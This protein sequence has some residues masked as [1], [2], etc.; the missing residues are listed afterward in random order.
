MIIRYPTGL[1]SNILPQNPQDS[2][3][4]TFVISN[5]PPP[6]TNLIFPK[7]PLGIVDKKKQ[8]REIDAVN[9]RN[10]V[11][12]LIF[13]V[14]K[15]RRDIEGNNGKMF[16][17]GQVLEFNN[18][19]TKTLSPMLV[20]SK[21]ITQHN[22]NK[23]NYD[24]LGVDSNEQQLIGDSSLLTYRKLSDELNIIKRKRENAEQLILLNQKIIND[25]NR[26]L[27]A[28][29]I[30]QQ[31]NVNDDDINQLIIKVERRKSL[32][33]QER[34]SAVNIANQ[35]SDMASKILDELRSISTVMV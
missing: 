14:S 29:K 4:I 2:G 26:T 33:E 31:Q 23:I 5:N 3:N 9:R 25:S 27:N 20:G 7:I 10:T 34:D 15:S 19:S 11:G 24:E 16:E 35:S 13:E 18:N 17:I 22:L 21:T 8:R 12:D 6:R 28:L 1:Y 30:V 32:A